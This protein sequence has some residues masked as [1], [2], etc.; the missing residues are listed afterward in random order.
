MNMQPPQLAG[1]FPIVATP[2]HPDGSP[3]TPDLERLID[4]IVDCGADGL[5]FPGVAS[6]FDQMTMAERQS[7][8]QIVITRVAGRKPVVIGVSASTADESLA[9]AQ[10]AR[11]AG[12]DAVMLMAPRSLATVDEQKRLFAHVGN[13]AD[14]PIILQN[15]PVPIGAGLSIESILA[16][17]AATPQVRW[18]KEETMPCGQR[19]S[20]LLAG[21][22]A[23]L[24]GVFGGAGGRYLADELA[25]G[26]IGTMPACEITDAHVALFARHRAGDAAGVRKLFNDVLPLLNFQ[27]VFRMAMTKE[28]L[29][30]RG[31]ISET[32]VRAPGPRLDAGDHVELTAIL[33]DLEPLL[34]GVTRRSAGVA[35]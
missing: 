35:G 5:V 31:V 15:Q 33:K 13:S 24:M 6:E 26:A 20:R 3:A 17:V 4:F 28:V 19:I 2:F 30:R 32:F 23:S 27:A 25:R 11:A 14:L 8:S 7:L 9:L 18:I 22:P 10:H 29:R 1:V 21:R 34:T 16:I 12:A